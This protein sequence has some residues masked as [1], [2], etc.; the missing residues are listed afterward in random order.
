MTEDQV[1]ERNQFARNEHG[2]LIYQMLE[3]KLATSLKE[4]RITE[5]SHS[6]SVINRTNI[7]IHPT[8]ASGSL[9]CLPVRS[10]VASNR[11]FPT[12]S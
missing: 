10:V 3:L 5:S 8:Y 1:M 12:I 9:G 2:F 6:A 4:S 7:A 11:R